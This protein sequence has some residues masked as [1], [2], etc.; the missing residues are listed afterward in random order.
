[1]SIFL[2][3]Y[4]FKFVSSCLNLSKFLFRL[5]RINYNNLI[6][7]L[8]TQTQVTAAIPVARQSERDGVLGEEW[9]RWVKDGMK[10]GRRGGSNSLDDFKVSSTVWVDHILIGRK[11]LRELLSHLIPT[12]LSLFL[13][14]LRTK[15]RNIRQKSLRAINYFREEL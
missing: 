15:S 11:A 8:S 12:G 1:M 3:R 2:L 13:S 7:E 10:P 14:S 4:P 6:P 9:G 5:Y